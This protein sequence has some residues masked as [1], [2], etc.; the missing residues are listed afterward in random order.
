MP[1][2]GPIK[3]IT[4][5]GVLESDPETGEMTL[6]AL[7]PGVTVEEVKANV[8]WPLRVRERLG[9]V[10]PPSAEELRLLRTVLDPK[11]LYLG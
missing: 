4:D 11:K 1:G 5:K 3:V 8:G 2:A 10:R 6:T 9:E 7:Y